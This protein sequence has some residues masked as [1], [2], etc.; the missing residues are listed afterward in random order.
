M[1]EVTCIIFADTGISPSQKGIP[2]KKKIPQIQS[3]NL[4]VRPPNLPDADDDPIVWGYARVST[5]DQTTEPQV[6][7]LT[8]AGV[9]RDRIIE[10]N[11][12]GGMLASLRP[13]L[14][15]LLWAL[16]SGDT[17]AVARLDRIG[18]DPADTLMTIR[19]L[20]AK[21]VIVQL[22]DMGTASNTPAGNLVIGVLASVAGWERAVLRERTREGLASARERGVRLGRR[23]RLSQHQ[24]KVAL[25]MADNGQSVSQISATLGVGRSIAHRALQ[26]LR[27]K[28]KADA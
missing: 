5:D 7:L 28:P 26:E 12:S 25:E 21:G 10:E 9:A 3:R 6:L 20:Q 14:A 8:K 16:R 18:R 13:R 23:P 1:A 17:L 11:I 24:K 15:G 4:M 2:M 19:D 22:L 27:S